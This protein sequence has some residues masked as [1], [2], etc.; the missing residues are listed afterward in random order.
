[1]L[2]RTTTDLSLALPDD[3][4]VSQRV[5]L[6][7]LADDAQVT[8]PDGAVVR[9]LRDPATGAARCGG[10]WPRVA[11]W[12]RLTVGDATALFH[13]RTLEDAPQRHAMAV[14]EQTRQRATRHAAGDAPRATTAEG[15][16]GASWPW[17]L[18]FLLAA[19][20]LWWLERRRRAA[21]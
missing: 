21:G 7:G 17:F 20:L 19:G 4:R 12:H 2:A 8:A 5:A 13:V 3:A 16:R 9:V 15:P 6:C 1:M 18:G 14:N 10:F 11:G